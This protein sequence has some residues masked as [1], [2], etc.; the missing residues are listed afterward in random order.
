MSA[1]RTAS[2]I[3]RIAFDLQAGKGLAGRVLSDDALYD[4]FLRAST[5]LTATLDE[6]RLLAG[7]ARSGE[8]TVATLLQDPLLAQRLKSSLE[9]V[10]SVVRKIDA[11]T[12]TIGVLVNDPT[13]ANDVASRMQFDMDNARNAAQEA[14]EAADALV[15]VS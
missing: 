8:G 9:G 4:E 14:V 5:T 13:I 7:D 15:A 2:S 10:D 1:S 11:G 3:E 12:G 6:V